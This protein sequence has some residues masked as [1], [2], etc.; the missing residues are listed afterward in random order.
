[1][2]TLSSIQETHDP[3]APL[4][5]EDLLSLLMEYCNDRIRD[6]A[7]SER[8]FTRE[9]TNDK[10]DIVVKGFGDGIATVANSFK[11][12]ITNQKTNAAE[13]ELKLD[14][15]VTYLEQL[16]Q[17]LGKNLETVTRAFNKHIKFCHLCSCNTCGKS[18]QT[19]D[20]LSLHQCSLHLH[21]ASLP[22]ETSTDQ[23]SCS[24]CSKTFPTVRDLYFHHCTIH[25]PCTLPT[26]STCSENCSDDLQPQE[27]Y[28]VQ[29]G[30]TRNFKCLDC[31]QTFSSPKD[32]TEHNMLQHQQEISQQPF[33]PSSPR[34]ND[35]LT[36]QNHLE[37]SPQSDHED[38]EF[39]LHDNDDYIQQCDGNDS[40]MSL[41]TASNTSEPPVKVRNAPYVLNKEKQISK[42]VRNSSL[43]NF[44]IEVT[45]PTNVNIQCSTGFYQLVAKPVLQGLL[46]PNLVVGGLAVSC[47]DPVT[48]KLDQLQRNVNTVLH[49]KVNINGEQ[50]SAT[51]HLHHTQQK[52]QV[53][54]RAAQWFVDN[55]LH[56]TFNKEAKENELN[57][58]SINTKVGAS[59]TKQSRAATMT[60]SAS[61]CFHC[62][63]QF[64][65]R[66]QAKSSPSFCANCS[67]NFHNTKANPCLLLHVCSG[68]PV[69]PSGN[70]TS[71]S[72]ALV[73][74]SSLSV[75]SSLS[76]PS[77]S[78]SSSTSTAAT[79]T[80]TSVVTP[81]TSS[82]PVP[83]SVTTSTHP[84][85]ITNP[86]LLRPHS[87][88]Q[89]P[90]T[91]CLNPGAPNFLP[92]NS[93]QS[94]PVVPAPNNKQKTRKEPASV[95]KDPKDI[96]IDFLKREL[97]IVKVNLID[98]ESEVNDLKRKNK[99]LAD[100]VSLLENNKQ[101][102]LSNKYSKPSASRAS[103]PA[104]SNPC[105]CGPSSSVMEPHV[106][107][108]VLDLLADLVRLNQ[109]QNHTNSSKTSSTSSLPKSCD[110][111]SVVQASPSVSP[112]SRTVVSTALSSPPM[113]S[114]ESTP[115]SSQ[116]P[117]VTSL[118]EFAS[119]LS[120]E[121]CE[122]GS[123]DPEQSQPPLNHHP[124]N[125]NILTNQ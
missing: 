41:D 110:Y 114:S 116:S 100:T 107:N 13:L 82:E 3:K 53:Q 62:K 42:L 115:L 124:L 70:S 92:H 89:A 78:S 52:I 8:E 32:F 28:T 34:N 93:V 83:S 22:V 15:K 14:T 65:N 49:F 10:I 80:I 44:E 90:S 19:I 121:L 12:D 40:L 61:N 4:S 11:E 38:L 108:K 94:V 7:K 2:A 6:N 58:R 67:Q 50:E 18:F 17:T 55:V 63:K 117:S 66:A 74:I 24:S 5:G 96:E 35:C 105:S 119:D 26:C 79:I 46:V 112:P 59:L 125:S 47:S 21:N 84:S 31:D 54:G 64:R 27:H 29:H 88:P 99:V 109:P 37:S 33:F 91:S 123:R 77:D 118:D 43:T 73:P 85:A 71:S 20:E 97:N 101:A 102:E 86:T 72:A 60:E 111:S 122:A 68:L 69:S 57:I 103:N 87:T 75:G 56:E 25:I 48:P 98:H 1:M 81:L 9:L 16:L 51:I 104:S 106:L 23:L 113:N 36:I 95:Q 30:Q 76:I 39:S 120:M 45:G